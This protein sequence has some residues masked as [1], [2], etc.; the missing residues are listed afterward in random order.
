M[1]NPTRKELINSPDQF[2]SASATTL[3][4]IKSNRKTFVAGVT[5]TIIII[6]GASA[7]YYWNK[8][9]QHEAMNAVY[10]AAENPKAL[11]VVINDYAGTK[12]AKIAQ[13]KL[14]RQAFAEGDYKK[15]QKEAAAFCSRWSAKDS[16]FWQARQLEAA[17]QLALGDNANAAATFAEC[18]ANSTDELRDQALFQQA[19]ALNNQ[20]KSA[21][22][23]KALSQI[24]GDYQAMGRSFGG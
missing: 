10:A 6:G 14:A 2:L 13:L 1:S 19:V 22:A 16:L 7:G 5:A 12:A 8:D 17:S 11:Q 18:A 4:W 9:R 24:K 20:N 23:Q 15:A 21:E 3:N